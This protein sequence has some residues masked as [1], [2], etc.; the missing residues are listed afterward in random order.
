MILTKFV[1]RT[2]WQK[3]QFEATVGCVYT[4]LK[5]FVMCGWSGEKYC[6]PTWVNWWLRWCSRRDI[7][8]HL[9]ILVR[10]KMQLYKEAVQQSPRWSQSFH[11]KAVSCLRKNLHQV[12]VI[13]IILEEIFLDNYWS[14]ILIWFLTIFKIL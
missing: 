12:E 5:S 14:W 6:D 8:K 3:I 11:Y 7:T 2:M 9:F 10:I 1:V 4:M 13:P